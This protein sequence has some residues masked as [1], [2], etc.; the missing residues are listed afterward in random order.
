MKPRVAIIADV[1]NWAW[2]RKARAL[3]QHLCG[4]FD[5]TVSYL[6]DKKPDTLPTGVDLYHT[7][8]VFQASLLP[9]GAPYVT[10]ITA[11]VWPGLEQRYGAVPIRRWAGEALAFHAN[12]RLL[13]REV[14]ARLGRPITYCPNG[15]DEAFFHRLRPAPR[16]RLVV[17]WVGKPNP[18]KGADI[19]REACRLAGVELRTVERTHRDAL[20]AEAMRDFY[21]G[22]N[23]VAVASDMDGT[24][25]HALEGAACECAVVGNRIG[26][27]PELLSGG[28]AGRLVER[29]AEGLAEAFR[30]LAADLPRTVQMGVEA[31]EAIKWAWTWR[32]LSKNYGAMWRAALEGKNRS[33]A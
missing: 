26:N 12:S 11:H 13:E 8:E 23:V 5:V 27:L 15:V 31:R 10:G 2:D 4:E 17:G 18:R 32:E 14:A 7:F 20:P 6:Y 9:P 19:V 21:Q 24:P 3:R 28:F 25:N 29:T 33:A 1:R 22:C 16:D 30:E